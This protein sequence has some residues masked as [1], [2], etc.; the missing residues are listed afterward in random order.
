MLFWSSTEFILLLENRVKAKSIGEKQ[1]A[2]ES[3]RNQFS[4]S[5]VSSE[6]IIGEIKAEL[7]E[8]TAKH[9]VLQWY[10]TYSPYYGMFYTHERRKVKCGEQMRK[11]FF[12]VWCFVVIGRKFLLIIFSEISRNTFYPDS[13]RNTKL[14]F[15][16]EIICAK[17]F[18]SRLFGGIPVFGWH[19]EEKVYTSTCNDVT[20]IPT[21]VSY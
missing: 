21:H 10:V 6:S 9:E 12:C 2:L 7:E 20:L 19:I 3:L 16:L 1:A 8:M 15:N 13:W 11:V 18:Q 17:I 5:S 4:S 14:Y